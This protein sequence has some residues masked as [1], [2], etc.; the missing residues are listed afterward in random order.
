MASSFI[1][2][3]II[4]VNTSACFSLLTDFFIKCVILLWWSF[5]KG[6]EISILLVACIALFLGDE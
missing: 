6:E 2:R 1:L 3:E 4:E 5:V